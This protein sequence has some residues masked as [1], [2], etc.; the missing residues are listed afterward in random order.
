MEARIAIQTIRL[1][2]YCLP[3][4]QPFE[5][6]YG[7]WR[8]RRGILIQVTDN[9]GRK[10]LGESAPLAGFGMETLAEAQIAL[11]QMQAC[12]VGI[13]FNHLSD[14]WNLLSDYARTPAARHGMEMALLD[15]IAQAQPC[16]LAQ[17]LNP[18]LPCFCKDVPVNATIGILSIAETVRKT[19]ELI[20]Q[21]YLYLKLK[22]GAQ[23]FAQDLTRIKTVRAIAGEH[24]QL[25]IDANQAWSV[26]QAI[27]NLQQL[28]C[29]KLEYVEQPVIASDVA[30]MAKV[31]QSVGIAIAADESV[32][33]LQQL[34]QIIALQAADVVILKPMA[35]GGILT[36]QLAARIAFEHGLD[37]VVTTTLEGAIARQGALHL[38]A[39]LR[40][41]RASGLATGELLAVDICDR[42]PQ[43][44]SGK[45]SLTETH[46]L[47]VTEARDFFEK[48]N[49]K[50][51]QK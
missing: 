11:E 12:S 46:G 28:D 29:L 50:I 15:L 42:Y 17:L 22:V 23:D 43:P 30:G 14:V 8:D 18:N 16:S 34:Q 48:Q 39:A 3:F 5:T 36:T 21:G 13:Q 4:R 45:L 7:V 20:G 37:V 10:G 49:L 40:L 25:R 44:R 31:R 47:G 33:N 26:E 24:I 51:I 9:F 38:A 32:S 1:Q 27:A 41:T 35:L 19:K 6:A 2:P